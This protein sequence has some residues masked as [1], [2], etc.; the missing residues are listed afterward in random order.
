LQESLEV[1]ENNGYLKK[2]GEIA[3]FIFVYNS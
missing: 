3:A 2:S 1:L